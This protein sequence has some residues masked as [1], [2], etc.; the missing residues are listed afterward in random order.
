MGSTSFWHQVK[1]W[2]WQNTG[3]KLLA[4]H[5]QC[6]HV[7][8]LYKEKGRGWT[9]IQNPLGRSC[10]KEEVIPQTKATWCYQHQLKCMN[11]IEAAINIP[12]REPGSKTIWDAG[13][14]RAYLCVIRRMLLHLYIGNTTVNCI[15]KKGEWSG[16]AWLQCILVVANTNTLH[17]HSHWLAILNDQHYIITYTCMTLTNSTVE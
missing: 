14:F 8:Q 7:Q 13:I 9:N 10:S 2:S 1:C 16:G 11:M 15:N 3:A 17:H 12:L 5:V 4:W 6:A